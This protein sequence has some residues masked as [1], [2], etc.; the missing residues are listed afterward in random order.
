MPLQDI[1]D[2]ARHLRGQFEMARAGSA[3]AVYVLAVAGGVAAGK[4]TFAGQLTQAMM[5]WAGRIEIVSTDGFLFPNA[6]LAER[7]LSMRKGFPESY[8]IDSLRGAITRIRSG[9]KTALPR[10][11]H[12]TYDVDSETPHVVDKPD[13]LILDG[14]HLG[15]IDAEALVRLVDC[16]IYLDAEEEAIEQWF[17]G[18][19]L[20]LMVEGRDDPKSFYHAFREMDDAARR[21]FARRVWLGINLPNL[22]DH[23]VKDRDRADVVVRKAADHSIAAIE[24]RQH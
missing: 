19:L 7:Q 15:R 10:Y 9:E 3:G 24:L 8:D 18:R 16:L 20:P 22:R 4:S 21:D 14:L 23:I 12:V 17:T 11:S 1:H 2:L 6:I 13:V 5:P